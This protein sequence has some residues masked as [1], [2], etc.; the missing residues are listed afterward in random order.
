MAVY[1]STWLL[2]VDGSNLLERT[3]KVYE[4]CPLNK[5][6]TRITTGVPD[7]V[8]DRLD[9][10]YEEEERIAIREES[11]GKYNGKV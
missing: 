1:L 11:E 3:R 10:I 6:G 8:W 2:S 5:D 7:I 9:R 4:R